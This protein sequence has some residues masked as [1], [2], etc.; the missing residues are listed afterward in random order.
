MSSRTNQRDRILALLKTDREVSLPEILG[1][2]VAQ[3]GARILELR[4]EGHRIVNRTERIDGKTCSWF[5]LVQ[6]T[7]TLFDK[8]LER[9]VDLG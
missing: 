2:G 6:T 5:R 3:Y 9:H 1:L 7:G 8:P 4:R